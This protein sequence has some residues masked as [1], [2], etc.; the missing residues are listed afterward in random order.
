MHPF[1]LLI[2]KAAVLA[3]LKVEC[4]SLCA[5]WAER[6]TAKPQKNLDNC[7][8]LTHFWG[9][10]IK[11]PEPQTDSPAAQSNSVMEEACK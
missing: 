3:G 11:V 4:C 7:Y 5:M 1:T 8:L 2:T 10:G 6:S 9:G